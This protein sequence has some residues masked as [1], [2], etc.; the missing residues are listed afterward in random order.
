MY[1]IRLAFCSD[2]HNSIRFR[3]NGTNAIT[4][5]LIVISVH[6]FEDLASGLYRS[7][8]ARYRSREASRRTNCWA[9]GERETLIRVIGDQHQPAKSSPP[10]PCESKTEKM[11][12]RI[13]K[14]TH[15]YPSC[16]RPYHL[17]SWLAFLFMMKK[18]ILPFLIQISVIVIS[19]LI[20][21]KDV[22]H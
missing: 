10:A 7:N 21:I 22:G 4:Y 16:S 19:L 15:I 18:K 6:S 3:S 5:G 14:Q 20:L 2:I 12:S 17:I 8:R 9:Y 13:Y 11:G 1:L